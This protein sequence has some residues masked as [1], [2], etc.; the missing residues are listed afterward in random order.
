MLSRSCRTSLRKL[1]PHRAGLLTSHYGRKSE[2]GNQRRY[3]MT[4]GLEGHVALDTC[5]FISAYPLTR[6]KRSGF[7]VRMRPGATL[8]DLLLM[9]APC[10]KQPRQTLPSSIRAPSSPRGRDPSGSPAR[11]VLSVFQ[12]VGLRC[13]RIERSAA[14]TSVSTVG[15][16]PPATRFATGG[17]AA[18]PGEVHLWPMLNSSSMLWPLIGTRGFVRTRLCQSERQLA[19]HRLST[20]SHHY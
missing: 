18:G 5:N 4:G 2:S 6:Q 15:D 13:A 8:L 16:R 19:E 14:S 11:Y 7:Q 20:A 10:F 3:S 12:C 9:V 17:N 1:V